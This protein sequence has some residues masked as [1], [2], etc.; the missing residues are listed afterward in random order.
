LFCGAG[1]LPF[2]RKLGRFPPKLGHRR[3]GIRDAK[4]C[5]LVY[6]TKQSRPFENTRLNCRTRYG[7]VLRPGVSIG[8]S[9]SGDRQC[10]QNN[11][12]CRCDPRQKRGHKL[13]L[14]AMRAAQRILQGAE[15]P[16]TGLWGSKPVSTSELFPGTPSLGSEGLV[17]AELHTDWVLRVG[18]CLTWL[19]TGHYRLERRRE[20]I[21]RTS[22]PS[23]RDSPCE[24]L[25]EKRAR[26]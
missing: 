13:S 4:K 3:R 24:T 10:G 8:G 20:D 16:R 1:A 26:T 2:H 21:P 22:T 17:R 25:Q 18:T 12:R 23:I 11:K 9:G 6:P 14:T 15:L 19:E 5:N 7:K